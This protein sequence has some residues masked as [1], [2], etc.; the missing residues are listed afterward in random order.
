MLMTFSLYTVS[1]LELAIFLHEHTILY[2]SIL[3]LVFVALLLLRYYIFLKFVTISVLIDYNVPT[4]KFW[5]IVFCTFYAYTYA[6][7]G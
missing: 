3:I 2:S 6:Y 4:S 1:E 7:R 5:Y